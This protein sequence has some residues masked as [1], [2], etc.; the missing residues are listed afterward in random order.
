MS[1]PD[2][3]GQ[4]IRKYP[5]RCRFAP[6]AAPGTRRGAK[7]IPETHHIFFHIFIKGGKYPYALFLSNAYSIYKIKKVSYIYITDYEIQAASRN[8]SCFHGSAYLRR[9]RRGY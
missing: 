4:N 6:S 3:G 1:I 5:I 9:F 7:K 8:I 2:A